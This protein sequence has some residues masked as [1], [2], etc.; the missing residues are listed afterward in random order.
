MAGM[1]YGRLVHGAPIGQRIMSGV[2]LS[3][4]EG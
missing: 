3:T 4:Q 2:I 1:N